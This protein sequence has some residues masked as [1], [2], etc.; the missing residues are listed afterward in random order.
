MAIVLTLVA[1]ALFP[2]VS[3]AAQR[4]SGEEIAAIDQYCEMLSVAEG[5]GPI[6]GAKDPLRAVLTP[7]VRAEL[8]AAGPA[9]TA[10]LALPAGAPV[11]A[12]SIDRRRLPGAADALIGTLGES[13]SPT[14]TARALGTLGDGGNGLSAVFR[15]ALLLSTFGL[16]AVGWI[17]YRT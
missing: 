17:R 12:G 5:R 13:R 6:S 2:A 9:G 10:L 16:T 7:G 8:E 3:A 11:L 14:A 1:T 15:W 4:C